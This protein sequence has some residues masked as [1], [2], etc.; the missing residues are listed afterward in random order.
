MSNTH[1]KIN[2]KHASMVHVSVKLNLTCTI[3]AHSIAAEN[4]DQIKE[5]VDSCAKFAKICKGQQSVSPNCIRLSMT[6]LPKHT[7]GNK[8]PAK[9]QLLIEKDPL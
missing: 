3:C 8:P 4:N 9:R 1:A 2:E 5:F 7:A 6:N